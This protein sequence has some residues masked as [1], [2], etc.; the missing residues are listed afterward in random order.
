M[1]IYN[2][3]TFDFLLKN[4]ISGQLHSQSILLTPLIANLRISLPYH[5][6]YPETIDRRANSIVMSKNDLNFEVIGCAMRVH[7][8]LGPGLLESTYEACLCYELKQVGLNVLRQKPI[9]LVY[10]EIQLEIG[11]RIDLLV[12]DQLILE[13]KAVERIDD[14]H[15]AQ[16]LTYLK[17]SNC[18]Q[19]LVLNFN[20]ASMKNGIKRVV[21]NHQ[22]L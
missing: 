1:R 3:N 11:Y 2:G 21:N 16:L 6:N 5:F 13:I 12:E 19:G 14:I 15:L 18:T 8:A 4:L 9:P 7:S 22:S 17:L 10:K 20:V